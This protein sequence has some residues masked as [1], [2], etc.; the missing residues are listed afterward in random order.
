MKAIRKNDAD[1]HYPS[2]RSA[3]GKRP[4]LTVAIDK[5]SRMIAGFHVSEAAP[6][7]DLV[8]SILE[9]SLADSVVVEI[10]HAPLDIIV[11]EPRNG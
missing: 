7:T 5:H 11:V 4:Y 3:V 1:S 6:D 2:K 9:S 8:R 10:D